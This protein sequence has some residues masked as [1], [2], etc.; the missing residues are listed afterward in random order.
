MWISKQE[1]EEGG[2]QCVDR[3]C[4][5][6]FFLI[7]P[8]HLLCCHPELC[9]KVNI[10]C[11]S[12]PTLDSG[13]HPG[14]CLEFCMFFL[15]VVLLFQSTN[16]CMSMKHLFWMYCEHLQSQLY[17]DHDHQHSDC[18]YNIGIGP[19][20]S[21]NNHVGEQHNVTHC[22]IFVEHFEGNIMKSVVS[23]F[24]LFG[25]SFVLELSILAHLLWPG[26]HC[27]TCI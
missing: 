26:G 23:C 20:N 25:S 9:Q 5:W 6:F 8:S 24:H 7:E 13:T 4:P 19:W 1:Y 27:Q 11:G 22:S 21:L 3:K 17:C 10:F 15:F 12:H 14:F 18:R 2:K 16:T